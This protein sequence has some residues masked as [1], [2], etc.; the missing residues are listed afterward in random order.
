MPPVAEGPARPRL[1]PPLL[2]VS[3]GQTLVHSS[4]CAG[5][6]AWRKLTIVH[7]R[8]RAQTNLSVDEL[9]DGGD[10][11]VEQHW[12]RDP[13]P[14]SGERRPTGELRTRSRLSPAAPAAL[15][16]SLMAG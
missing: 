15:G 10:R 6:M 12:H 7:H 13:Q 11:E 1:G 3:S 5:Q 8:C 4:L 2:S 16:I 9:S 14:R